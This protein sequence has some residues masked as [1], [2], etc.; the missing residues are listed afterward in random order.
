M[1]FQ[2]DTKEEFDTWHNALCLELGYPEIVDG[3]IITH[4][5]TQAFKYEGVYI[6]YVD[7][8]YAT[9]LIPIVY[10]R[11]KALDSINE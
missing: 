7:E 4:S 3:K 6:A 1:Y 9:G 2:W 10:D 5:Y 11:Q 8:Q